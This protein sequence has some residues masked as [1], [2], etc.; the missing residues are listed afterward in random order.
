LTEKSGLKA[1]GPETP[2]KRIVRRLAEIHPDVSASRLKRAVM[3]GQ[4]TVNGTIER[5]AG[6]L[7]QTAEAVVWDANRPT[8]RRTTSALSVLFEDDDAVLV[9]KPAGLLTHATAEKEKDTLAARVSNYLASQAKRRPYLGVVHRLDKDT[10]GLVAFAKSR[11]GL[12]WMQSQLR[13]HEA[14]RIYIAVVEGDVAPDQGRFEGLLVRDRG[15][16]R[17]GVARPGQPGETATTNWRVLERFGIATLVEVQLETGRTHQI[18]I[19][20]AHAEHPLVGDPVYRD[21][22]RKPFPI[23]FPRQALHAQVLGF[24]TVSGSHVVR[25]AE[26]PADFQ[27]LLASLRRLPKPSGP[28]NKK[29]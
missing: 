7:V 23:P 15:D 5:N 8:M 28:R 24:D 27:E 10:S 3:E 13:T 19:H 22:E 11:R 29:G 6:A 18:R 9:F 4:V 20:F 1:D 17:R 12:Q 26:P 14:E 2:P 21:R 25:R 16:G